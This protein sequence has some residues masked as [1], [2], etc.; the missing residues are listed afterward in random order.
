MIS[1][2]LK[3]SWR[4]HGGLHL[5]E[6][7]LESSNQG[8]QPYFIPKKLILPLQQH[9]GNPAEPIV[10]V[11]DLVR[12]GQLIAMAK[13]YISA[14]V[15]APTSGKIVDIREHAIPH[16][17]G[18]TAT[19][20]FIETDGKDEWIETTESL[21]LAS[22]LDPRELRNRI[23]AA[24]IVGLGGAGF[25][26]FIKLNPGQKSEIETLVINGAECEPYIT[27]D[28]VLMRERAREIIL[29]AQLMMKA[30]HAK[31]CLIGIEDNKPEAIAA[32]QAALPNN[33]PAQ[34]Q[35]LPT[36]YPGG[37]EKQLIFSLTG[38][39]VPSQGIPLDIGLVCHNVGTAFSVYEAIYLGRPQLKRVVTFTGNAAA[40][41]H[42]REALIGTTVSDFINYCGDK[43]GEIDEV[44]LGGPMMGFA[45]QDTQVPLIKTTNCLILNSH[46]KSAGFPQATSATLPC[47]RCGDCAEAC[48]MKLLPQQ[49]YW[50]AKAKEFDK[51][52]DYSLFDCIECGCCSYVCPS[53]IPLVQYFRFAKNSI[54]TAEQ[55]RKK[56]DAARERF[57][58][59]AVRIEEAKREKEERLR[60][61][62]AALHT[63][64]TP[65]Q[66][67]PK[68]A[69]IQAA[70]ARVKEKKSALAIEPKN[71]DQL[72]TSQQ[73]KIAE[74]DA[75]RQQ[76][77]EP[78]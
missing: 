26:S 71:I 13:G 59:R 64:G 25:P 60:I 7:K 39:E 49:L 74:I 3:K 15:H 2:M 76:A 72:T 48:P 53:Q 56:S 31:Q 4:F 12:K 77:R 61:R 28:D 6:H 10:A 24:G 65:Q 5:E 17:S 23:R 30:L 46:A 45:L 8:I 14:P 32:M 34:I 68:K 11:G 63:E 38:K 18:L 16:V 19:C 50:H 40:I 1:A 43:E 21:P 47:I 35:P 22:S 33:C 36:L 41:P 44:I 75:K 73:K 54:W 29:G 37:G 51:V 27:C 67:D 55:E 62:K 69:E 78:K 58:S 70:L 42:N 20:I 57:E 9:L 66:E 52:Q